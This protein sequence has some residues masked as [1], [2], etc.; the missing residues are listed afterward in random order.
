MGSMG[1]GSKATAKNIVKLE[2]GPPGGGWAADPEDDKI[3]YLRPDWSVSFAENNAWHSWAVTFIRKKGHT[4]NVHMSKQYLKGKTDRDIMDR[5]EAN[6][7]YWKGK[8]SKVQKVHNKKNDNESAESD[9]SEVSDDEDATEQALCKSRRYAR[10]R[11][12]VREAAKLDVPE[13][14]FF[15]VPAYQSTDESDQDDGIDPDTDTEK[16][17]EVR[18]PS[19]KKPWITRPPLYRGAEVSHRFIYIGKLSL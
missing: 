9:E 12:E 15:F 1:L 19:V 17:A 11:K 5:I 13:L 14:D 18:V 3:F 16:S 10:K 8:I 2:P 7:R 4:F 6:F